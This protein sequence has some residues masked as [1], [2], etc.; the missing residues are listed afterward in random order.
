MSFFPVAHQLKLPGTNQFIRQASSSLL[1]SPLT[2]GLKATLKQEAR[3]VP[4]TVESLMLSD[5]Q[6]SLN[7]Y[8][9]ASMLN[10]EDFIQLDDI[11]VRDELMNALVAIDCE[12]VRTCVGS[13]LYGTIV[14]T[15]LR[16]P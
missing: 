1:F 11:P 4:V 6:L 13:E 15:F 12:M 9:D 10:L 8:P 14:L 16:A 5:E 7:E 3:A 2:K